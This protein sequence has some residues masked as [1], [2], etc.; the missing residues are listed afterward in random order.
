[1]VAQL[2]ATLEAVV[3]VVIHIHPRIS[4]I[5][6]QIF[7]H[8]GQLPAEEVTDSMPLEHGRIYVA[9]PDRHLVVE[10]GQVHSSKGP[11]EHHMRPSIDATFRTAA[12][13]YGERVVGV[14]LTG[15]LDDGVAGLREIKHRG[16]IAIVQSPEEAPYPSMPLSALREITVDYTVPLPEIGPLL[17]RL[18]AG[19]GTARVK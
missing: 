18:A 13:A 16:G 1:L 4:S 3:L 9:A 2:P 17:C 10:R 11:K 8:S 7:S 19:D 15:S 14:V 5:L 12:E 6:P